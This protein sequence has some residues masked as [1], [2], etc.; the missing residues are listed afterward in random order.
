MRI[1]LVSALPPPAGGIAIWT[2]RYLTY[3]QE[4]NI[5]VDLVNIALSGSRRDKINNKTRLMDEVSRTRHIMNAMNKRLD[6]G[7]PSVV[8]MNTSCG[9]FGIFRDLLCVRA[10]NKR[11]V[12]VVLHFHCNVENMIQGRA[13]TWALRQMTNIASQAIVLNET[14]QK[15]VAVLTKKKSNHCAEFCK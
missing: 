5:D 12:P 14:S 1:L 4:N 11:N 3:C 2:E 9:S 13:R 15:Y 7:R 8:H 10:A 6:E